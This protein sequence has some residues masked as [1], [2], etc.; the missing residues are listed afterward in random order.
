MCTAPPRKASNECRNDKGKFFLTHALFEFFS[1][2]LDDQNSSFREK[3]SEE[4]SEK[5]AAQDL[6]LTWSFLCLNQK[7]Y[8]TFMFL[9]V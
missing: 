1:V 9:Y 6:P 2:L 5:A 3:E 8:F 4:K 7:Y